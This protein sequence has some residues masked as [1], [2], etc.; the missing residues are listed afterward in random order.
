MQ[1]RIAEDLKLL[2]G[3]QDSLQDSN[4]QKESVEPY[5]KSVDSL[6]SSSSSRSLLSCSDS[7]LMGD[8][9][10]VVLDT[11]SRV[12]AVECR[13]LNEEDAQ[14]YVHDITRT[15]G[16]LRENFQLNSDASVSTANSLI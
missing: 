4:N 11:L 12:L 16:P 7:H 8:V 13:A 9:T 15:Y 3:G 6:T 5:K 2:D 1:R 14:T 10:S